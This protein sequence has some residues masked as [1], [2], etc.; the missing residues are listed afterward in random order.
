MTSSERTLRAMR[1]QLQFELAQIV[2]DVARA[3]QLSTSAEH[4]VS[5]FARQCESCVSE[6][7]AAMDR[8]HLNPALLEALRCVHRLQRA[9]LRESETKLA[10]ARLHEQRTRDELAAA[11]NRELSLERAWRSELRKQLQKRQTLEFA[12]ADDLWLQRSRRRLA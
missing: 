2:V 4:A 1:T 12:V 3:T 6:L 10:A 11:R 9:A 8:S 7:R 5:T